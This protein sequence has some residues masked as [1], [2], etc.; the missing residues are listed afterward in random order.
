MSFRDVLDNM[1]RTSS[2]EELPMELFVD[3]LVEDTY[4][5]HESPTSENISLKLKRKLT[6]YVLLSD[7]KLRT[8]AAA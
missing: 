4:S 2:W 7:K 3:D 8:S 1:L 6:Q 5:N